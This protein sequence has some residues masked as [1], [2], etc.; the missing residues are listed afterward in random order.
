VAY[1][2][3]KAMTAQNSE[4]GPIHGLEAA[5]EKTR[6]E[7]IER[8]ASKSVKNGPISIDA[9]GPLASVQIALMAVRE[10]IAL[11]DTKLG[12]GSEKPLK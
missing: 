12:G 10:E 11:H 9:L 7:E 8:L 1:E 3:L 6:L 4:R 5:L 2:E